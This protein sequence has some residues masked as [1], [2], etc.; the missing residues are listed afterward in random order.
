[1]NASSP[2]FRESVPPVIVTVPLE[3]MESSE[4]LMLNV[5]PRSERDAPA[6][7]FCAVGCVGGFCIL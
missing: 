2:D 7:S 6:F 5:P 1:M 3:W 4:E